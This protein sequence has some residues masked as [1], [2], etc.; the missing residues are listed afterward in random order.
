MFRA[1]GGLSGSIQATSAAGAR[2]TA[3]MNR[4]QTLRR[5]EIASDEAQIL[6]ALREFVTDPANGHDPRLATL[7]NNASDASDVPGIA[8]ELTRFRLAARTQEVGTAD[9]EAVFARASVRLAELHDRTGKWKAYKD[10][11][12]TDHPGD[13]TDPNDKKTNGAP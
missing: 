3:H 11:Q 5:I 10:R 8:L 7:L 9:L 12:A 1:T 2:P 4:D 6:A 13:A